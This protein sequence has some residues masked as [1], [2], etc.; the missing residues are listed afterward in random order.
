MFR[1]KSKKVHLYAETKQMIEPSCIKLLT[2][3][4]IESEQVRMKYP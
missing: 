4:H 3:I 1:K 2:H